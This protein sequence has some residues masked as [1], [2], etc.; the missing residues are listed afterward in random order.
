VTQKDMTAPMQSFLIGSLMLLAIGSGSKSQTKPLFY[1]FDFG[2]SGVRCCMIDSVKAIVH[3]DSLSWSS[4]Q[5]TEST[6]EVSK[7]WE[8]AMDQLLE[9]TPEKFRENVERI[10]IS[11]T[12]SS[13]L[14]YDVESASVSRQPRMYDFNVLLQNNKSFFGEKAMTA[15]QLVCPKGSAANAPTST[16]AKVLSWNFENPFTPSERLVHQ[17][18]YLIHH[19]TST[20]S[21]GGAETSFT[22]DWHN[23]LKLGYDV[24]SLEYP[25][26]MTELLLQEKILNKFVP[27]V[28]EPGRSV[29][30]LEPR[31]IAMGYSEHCG[32]VA[33]NTNLSPDLL[34]SFNYGA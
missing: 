20:H 15:I 18:D 23:A 12:S 8:L 32:V 14:I 22:S 17:A 33:G 27:M 10:C 11:G 5:T 28:V 29:G 30:L 25:T 24:H 19:I 7:S 26:W 9:R 1:G 13:A 3:E 16:L 2:T 21:T 6:L 4:I 31:L 34:Q